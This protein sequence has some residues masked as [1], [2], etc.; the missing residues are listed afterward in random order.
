MFTGNLSTWTEKYE[1]SEWMD[2][3]M[4][5]SE[6]E[7]ANR[8]KNERSKT[9]V[10]RLE[11]N[12][13]K[14]ETHKK[15]ELGTLKQKR[16]ESYIQTHIL[17]C[18]GLSSIVHTFQARKRVGPSEHNTTTTLNRSNISV[19]PPNAIALKAFASN[20]ICVCWWYTANEQASEKC[21]ILAKRSLFGSHEC[22]LL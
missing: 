3:R 15:N 11:N 8:I 21:S 12:N 9:T 17:V 10:Q 19:D 14:E 4:N 1:L 6:T 18:T 2:G 13:N 20:T 7:M 22:D 5:G 16:I